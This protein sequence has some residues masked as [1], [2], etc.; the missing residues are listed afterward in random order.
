MHFLTPFFITNCKWNSLVILPEHICYAS[1]QL[2]LVLADLSWWLIE[3]LF[4][5]WKS[6]LYLTHGTIRFSE[7]V[8]RQEYYD[9]HAIMCA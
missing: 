6:I 3:K 1:C 9:T 5:E 8:Y 4:L 7:P 2:I